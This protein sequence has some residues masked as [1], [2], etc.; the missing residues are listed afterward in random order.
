M[1]GMI[2][3]AK[4]KEFIDEELVTETEEIVEDIKEAVEDT[5]EKSAEVAEEVVETAAEAVEETAEKAEEIV[6]KLDKFA[7]AKEAVAA[8]LNDMTT[9]Y[10]NGT[11]TA[12]LVETWMGKTTALARENMDWTKV[13]EG[14]D[15]SFLIQNPHF[16]FGQYGPN[17]SST[18]YGNEES[19][20][21]WTL[22]SGA[23]KELRA[24]THN[25]EAWHQMFD[26]SQTLPNMPAGVYDLTLQGFVRHD[27]AQ[28]TD[29][30]YLYAGVSTRAIML[31][32][33]QWNTEPIF[34][35]GVE[36]LGDN[37]YDVEHQ[38]T[39]G[40]SHWVDNGMT[41]SFYWF[42]T[43]NP[44]AVEQGGQE[45]DCY[46]TNHLKVVLA[47]DGNFTIGLHCDTNT[48]WVIWDNFQLKY[49]GNPASIYTESI[50]EKLKL[51]RIPFSVQSSR[52]P[53]RK[54]SEAGIRPPSP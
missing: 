7:A 11:A 15:I 5:A 27:D 47:Q 37:H 32:T 31:C 20:P 44:N 1:K 17:E 14:T 29:Q 35:N 42:Q 4:K 50:Y 28:I 43:V 33:D 21:G 39:E 41:G 23:I 18:Y 52:S 53:L 46:Y 13:D 6:A 30:T 3:L 19:T 8:H 45:G 38:Q 9:A 40:P 36:T 2:A 12:E 48:D 24:A 10:N 26:F 54:S 22:N 34:Y 25:I 16:K 51:R 49:L